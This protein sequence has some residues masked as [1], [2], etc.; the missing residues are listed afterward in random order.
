MKPLLFL[1]YTNNLPKVLNSN[2]KLF[3]NDTYLLFVVK[4]ISLSQIE[5]N[6]DLTKTDILTYQWKM[7]FNPDKTFIWKANR[8]LYLRSYHIVDGEKKQY[9]GEACIIFTFDFVVTKTLS[10]FEAWCFAKLIL[11]FSNEVLNFCVM[12]YLTN[13]KTCIAGSMIWVLCLS[14]YYWIFFC[15]LLWLKKFI[16]YVF[17][18]F[19]LQLV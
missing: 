9:I 17:G 11:L 16:N 8:P 4:G 5:L 13:D 6:E 3:A 7:S 2:S 1:I 19:S 12:Y 15:I 10:R 18:E 14:K